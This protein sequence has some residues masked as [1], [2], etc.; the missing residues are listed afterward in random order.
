MHSFIKSALNHIAALMTGQIDEAHAVQAAWNLMGF[1]DTVCRIRDGQLPKSLASELPFDK[2]A[3]MYGD[4][5]DL[6]E[7]KNG[8]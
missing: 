5:V 1:V 6:T 2:V 4:I 3:L 8:E 7:P